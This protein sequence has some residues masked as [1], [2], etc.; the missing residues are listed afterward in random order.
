MCFLKAIYTRTI[1]LIKR[2][3]YLGLR[4][5]LLMIPF[6]WE[7][8]H[9]CPICDSMSVFTSCR[10]E[11]Q[12]NPADKEGQFSSFVSQ[13]DIP[14]QFA[15]SLKCKKRSTFYAKWSNSPD[16][17]ADLWDLCEVKFRRMREKLKAS[18]VISRIFQGVTLFALLVRIILQ[19]LDTKLMA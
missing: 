9:L 14:L 13:S 6:H 2:A 7:A 12:G 19:E 3:N 5:I 8:H 4:C 18:F 10:I 16:K 15:Y 1:I 11:W 17:R